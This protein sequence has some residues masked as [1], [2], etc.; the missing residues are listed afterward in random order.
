MLLLLYQVTGKDK[1]RK[2]AGLLRE[3]LRT[4]PRTSEGNFWH[5]QIYPGQVWLDGLYMGQP[6]FA[7]YAELFH[8]DSVFT[9]IARQFMNMERHARDPRSGLL[10][11]AWDETRSQKW[12]D[13][14]TGLSPHVWGR[15]L[16]WYGMA[17][18]D[19]LDHFPQ[20]H[21]YR[22]SLVGIL[23][24]FAK[25]VVQVQDASS[26]LWYDVPDVPSD[27][28]NY[29]EASASSMLVY[30]LARA[31]RL[32]YIAPSYFKSACK[33][34]EGIC[35]QFVKLVNG[36]Y[37]LNGT[38]SVSG[39]GGQ[40]YRDGSF[41]YYM[42]EPV[43]VNDPKGLGAF[44]QCAVEMEIPASKKPGKHPTV[45]LDRYFNNEW[46]KD[47]TGR[48]VRYHYTWEDM[49]NSGFS[50]LGSVFT[51]NGAD[52]ASLD[53]R[54]V[55]SV[56]KNASV[57]I[58]VDPDTDKETARLHQASEDDIKV[59]SDW[60]KKGGVLV[61]LGN[62]A[63]NANLKELNQLASR[64]GISFNE[65]NFNLV[66]NDRFE[67]GAVMVK[68]GPIFNKPHQLYIKELSTL[69]LSAPAK[70]VVTKEGRNIFAIAS[71]GKGK[72]LAL[73]D[74]W[75]YNEY[76]DGRKLPKEFDNYDAACELVRWCL[77]N[78]K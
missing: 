13:A 10:Y 2:A 76:L 63:G 44:I 35:R 1:Y 42:S 46:K 50:M 39:L 17:L 11:H 57:Y 19:V 72:V 15:A 38:V 8:E 74:P 20:N 29:F 59:I 18:V 71:Y 75:L 64:F 48:E 77:S 62:D 41:T 22:D 69:Q 54:P 24:R 5:K 37:Q 45:L 3:Q 30:T 23:Q 49:A 26:G 7:T 25:A 78:G 28:A 53:S 56:L 4:H 51:R 31:S 55:A 33:G 34:Y 9:D 61:L 58:I 47:A 6:F 27:P 65:D 68:P 43:V 40:P 52:T 21:P 32:G 14:R 70:A 12:A 66:A 60:V 67:Q 36:R 73:G 16:G